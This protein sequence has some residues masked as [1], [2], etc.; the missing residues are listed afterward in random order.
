MEGA[1][2]TL[3]YNIHNDPFFNEARE[4]L[5]VNA[6]YHGA[7]N[8]FD[9]NTLTVQQHFKPYAQTFINVGYAVE[10]MIEGVSDNYDAV[11]LL[12]PKNAI[13]ARYMIAQAL[14]R[15]KDGGRFICAADNNAG[16]GRL[17]KILQE[18]GLSD[19]AQESRNKAKLVSG[20]KGNL[21]SECIDK[22]IVAGGV[23]DILD[24]QYRS[25]PGVFGWN[26]IDTGSSLMVE[27]LPNDIKGAGADF[28]CGYGYLSDFVLSQY[29]DVKSLV[30]IDADARALDLCAHNLNHRAGRFECAWRDL[31]AAQ[32]DLFGLDFIIMNPPFHDGKASDSG[33]GVSFIRSAHAALRKGGRLYMVANKQL[34]YERA[35]ND[36]YSDVIKLREER[37]FK[38]FEVVK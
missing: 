35:L 27:C 17:K 26:K 32:G 33:I 36:L 7:L 16:G 11:I 9:R 13:E 24:G 28:G 23:Q 15:L 38:V 2:S 29:D 37:G 14:M 12:S 18:F 6:H 10:P 3:F 21:D 19:I 4:V 30:C 8:V 1:L 25:K 5:Y 20:M 34:P 31:T 22:A